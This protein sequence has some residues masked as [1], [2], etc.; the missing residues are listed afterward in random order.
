LAAGSNEEDQGMKRTSNSII[1]SFLAFTLTTAGGVAVAQE[2]PPAVTQDT[3]FQ[4]MNLEGEQPL[5]SREI[6]DRIG[7]LLR[8]NGAVT[9]TVRV[10]VSDGLVTLTGEVPHALARDQAEE[11]AAT[12]R[13]VESVVNNISIVPPTN[14]SDEQIHEEVR[15]EL[16]NDPATKSFRVNV[17]VQ[18]GVVTLDGEAGSYKEKQ[19]ASTIAKSV[20]GV[21]GVENNMSV[22]YE[23]DR[24]DME[25][26]RDIQ[27]A[28]RWDALVDERFVT[29]EVKNGFVTLKGTV[30]T[31]AEKTEA[32]LD[33][34][35]TGTLGVD[36]TMLIVDAF[37]VPKEFLGRAMIHRTTS[38]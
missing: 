35:V 32:T 7:R 20:R 33:A 27:Q 23:Q 11:I 17:L 31:A 16:M 34:W 28:L 13:G 18:D 9:G 21:R 15:W 30:R 25:V 4:E 14:V 5:T 37:D 24:P 6:A 26:L 3:V 10:Q 19:L 29:V 38:L 2:S 22:Q 8:M 1:I 12:V 36:N